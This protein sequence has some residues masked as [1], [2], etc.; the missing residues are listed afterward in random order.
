M[1]IYGKGS[2][3]CYAYHIWK[4]CKC[5]VGRKN[6]VFLWL[7]SK[8]IHL[9]FFSLHQSVAK[10]QKP[11]T[12]Y[13][14]LLYCFVEIQKRK[15]DSLVLSLFKLQQQKSKQLNLV[16]GFWFLVT[17]WLSLLRNRSLE[18]FHF[19]IDSNSEICN[20]YFL[21]ISEISL[22]VHNA[23]K[24]WLAWGDNSEIIG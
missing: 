2:V 21:D 20:R 8:F 11:N 7:S 24:N 23:D 4:D 13:L 14:C 1:R 22:Y 6:D 17:S 12:K 3:F 9:G 15:R 18:F 16:F 19:S 10:N 5:S